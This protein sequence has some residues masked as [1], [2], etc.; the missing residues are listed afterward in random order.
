M[1]ENWDLAYC[2]MVEFYYIMHY[3]VSWYRA[4]FLAM[5]KTDM[6]LVLMECDFSQR[7]WTINQHKNCK[8]R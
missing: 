8:L 6:M 4:R 7:K 5:N 3:F 2:F 1:I